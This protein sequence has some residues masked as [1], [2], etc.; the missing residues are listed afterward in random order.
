VVP[1]GDNRSSVRSERE[2]GSLV[3]RSERS[4]VTARSGSHLA[5]SK[6][7]ERHVAFEVPVMVHDDRSH[8]AVGTHRDTRSR[9]LEKV[10]LREAPRVPEHGW[11]RRARRY[12]RSAIGGEGHGEERESWDRAGVVL[13]PRRYPFRSGR[14]ERNRVALNEELPSVQV[15]GRDESRSIWAERDHV[16]RA[17]GRGLAALGPSRNVHRY[18]LVVRGDGHEAPTIGTER[19]TFGSRSHLEAADERVPSCI[20]EVD[21][22]SLAAGRERLPIRRD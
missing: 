9:D 12:K 2:P 7:Q 6:V 4:V 5:R 22:R 14:S 3:L 18:D 11:P 16:Y 13:A 10:N 8:G 1:H 21:H 19:C 20:E 17:L 15:L